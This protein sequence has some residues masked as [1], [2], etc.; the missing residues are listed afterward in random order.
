MNK[1]DPYRFSEV[2]K[3][4]TRLEMRT[5]GNQCIDENQSILTALFHRGLEFSRVVLPTER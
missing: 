4:K 3:R 1:T 5:D 2:T